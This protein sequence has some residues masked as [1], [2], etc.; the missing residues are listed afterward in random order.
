[1]SEHAKEVAAKAAEIGGACISF[2]CGT[3][4]WLA[5][6]HDAI[7]SIGIIG[8]VFIA[9]AGFV[10]NTYYQRRR[11]SM[12]FRYPKVTDGND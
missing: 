5:D 2:G 8:G 1:M 6:N 10:V 4:R 11:D 9:V 12:I 7:S 3:M